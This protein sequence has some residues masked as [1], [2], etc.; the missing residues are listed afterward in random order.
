MYINHY[1]TPLTN[2]TLSLSLRSIAI[3]LLILFASLGNAKIPER[4]KVAYVEF[5]PIEYKGDDNLPAGSFIKLTETVLNN[6][7]IEFDFIYLPIARAY[8]YLKEGK[9]DMWPG[10][11]G[12]PA[13]QGYVIESKSIPATITL[14]AWYLKGTPPITQVKELSGTNTILVNGYT[15]GGLLYKITDAGFGMKAFFTPNHESGLKM[16][17]LRRGDYFLDY[18]EP[19]IAQLRDSPVENLEHSV[20]NKRNASFL[21]SE[22]YTNAEQL[23]KILDQSYSELVKNGTIKTTTHK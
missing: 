6:A 21:V 8:L 4:L 19:I 22:K 13:L 15:Y 12:I 10:L 11:S 17:Q 23:I 1:S 5:P 20:L 16:L 2:N 7:N 3:L 14:S 18:N 9:V